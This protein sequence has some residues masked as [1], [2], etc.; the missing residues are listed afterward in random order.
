[1]QKALKN[2]GIDCN[3]KKIPRLMNE[4]KLLAKVKKFKATTNSNHKLPVEPNRLKRIFFAIR[5]NVAWVG[6][7]TY[8]WTEQG[9]LYLATV[10]DLC[11]RKVKGWAMGERI[12][13]DLAVSA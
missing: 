4:L 2:E 1:M 9:W 13:T 12:T 5:P 7:I 10:I 6:Y 3:H 8:I 11:S